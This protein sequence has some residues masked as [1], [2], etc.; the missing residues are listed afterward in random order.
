MDPSKWSQFDSEDDVLI[1]G[2]FLNGFLHEK[3]SSLSVRV[4]LPHSISKDRAKN[5]SSK[6]VRHFQLSWSTMAQIIQIV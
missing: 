2:I 4:D 3:N 5:L 6:D 1:H